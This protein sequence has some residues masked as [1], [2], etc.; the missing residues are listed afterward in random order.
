[1]Q[2]KT[3]V[4]QEQRALLDAAKLMDKSARQ[5]TG[6]GRLLLN[7]AMGHILARVYQNGYFL[8]GNN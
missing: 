4:K 5:T 2:L 8:Y 6:E 3:K 1:M 7:N